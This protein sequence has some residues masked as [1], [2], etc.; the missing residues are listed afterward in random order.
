MLA[1][2]RLLVAILIAGISIP[3]ISASAQGGGGVG[4]QL[5]EAPTDRRDDPRAHVH[6]VDHLA[7]GAT[8]ERTL[9]VVNT[10]DA[11][12]EIELYAGAATIADGAFL[13]ADPGEENEL[14]S[15]IELSE[16]RVRLAA[17]AR[18]RVSATI[19]VPPDASE[20][21]RYAAVW[22]QP[23]AATAAGSTVVNRAGVRIYLSVGEG[24]EPAA[25]FVIRSLR[26]ERAPDGQPIV[27]AQ[28]VNTGERALD[29]SGEL[30]LQEGPG[31][32]QAGPFPADLG[33][34]LGIGQ[35]GPVTVVLD[36]ALPA[37]PWNAVL[38]LR[39]GQLERAAEALIEFPD[40]AGATSEPVDATE[41]P[42]HQDRG[43]LLPLALGLLLLALLLV[44]LVWYLRRRREEDADGDQAEAEAARIDAAP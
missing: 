4:L 20:G 7:P 31:G 41:V 30:V 11:S 36:P 10:T 40:E 28:V 3:A 18:Q 33:T 23:P 29:M 35:E 22:A 32:L 42:L 2:R 19:A 9:E 37:G 43:F 6:I 12:L 27:A 24:G 14:S 17:N 26:A 5:V 13:P 44:F 8:I 16:E 1:H 15:W 39:S 34:T 21:E 38:T 25:D